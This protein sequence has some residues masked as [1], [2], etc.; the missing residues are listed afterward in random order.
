MA[1]PRWAKLRTAELLPCC[2]EY[3]TPAGVVW[4]L[5]L[6]TAGESLVQKA[7][8]LKEN[9]SGDKSLKAHAGTHLLYWM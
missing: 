4:G 9:L 5:P 7:Q 1:L 2:N 8:W 3:T 6:G